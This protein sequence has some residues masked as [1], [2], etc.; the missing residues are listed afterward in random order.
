MIYLPEAS[1][2]FQQFA[3]D[4]EKALAKNS[5]VVICISEG[6]SDSQGK[7]ICEYADEARVDTFGH[8]MLTGSGKMLENFVRDRFGVKVRSIELNVNQRCSGM[9]ASKTD[10]EEAVEAGAQGVRAALRGL[11]GIMVAFRRLSSQPYEMECIGVDVNQ[12]CNRE[13]LFPLSWITEDGTDVTEEFIQYALPLIQ[14][15]P[16]RTFS[17]GRPV[18]LYRAPKQEK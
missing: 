11:T 4:V 13:K 17:Q 9:L 7:F 18:Y 15:E 14:G 5:S 16:E 1:F 2:D 3:S 12:V 6:I 8:K 10:I